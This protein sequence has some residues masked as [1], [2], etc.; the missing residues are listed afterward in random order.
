MVNQGQDTSNILD[1]YK[2]CGCI[3]HRILREEP[4]EKRPAKNQADGRTEPKDTE[5]YVC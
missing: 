5:V 4:Q 1:A 3:M 2:N